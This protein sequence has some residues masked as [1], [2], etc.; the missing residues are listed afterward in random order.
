MA[1]GY[2]QAMVHGI[3]KFD[4]TERTEHAEKHDVYVYVCFRSSLSF[5]F[6]CFISVLILKVF[7]ST[8]ILKNFQVGIIFL[9][10]KKIILK[11]IYL[12]KKS[13][14]KIRKEIGNW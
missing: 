3:A 5:L 7:V 12:L 13:S 8:I 2:W 14:S 11:E 4:L 1:S 10:L 6:Q 9:Y